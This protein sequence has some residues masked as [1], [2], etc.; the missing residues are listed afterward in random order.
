MGLFR[1]N[2]YAKAFHF[3]VVGELSS[4]MANKGKMMS[5]EG[6][7]KDIMP[8]ISEPFSAVITIR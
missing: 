2:T 3:D 8:K 1:T 4:F 5:F 7:A 6:A